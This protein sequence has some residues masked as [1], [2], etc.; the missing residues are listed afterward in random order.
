MGNYF[1]IGDKIF[2]FQAWLMWHAIGKLCEEQFIFNYW[3]LKGPSSNWQ[4]F[5]YISGIFSKLI[6]TFVENFMKYD[7]KGIASHNYLRYQI[8]FCRTAII[9]K[10]VSK[11]FSQTFQIEKAGTNEQDIYLTF[12]LNVNKWINIENLQDLQVFC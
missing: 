12:L 4:W 6:I 7:L 5:W 1:L 3:L 11:I 10:I 2:P 9:F 8:A